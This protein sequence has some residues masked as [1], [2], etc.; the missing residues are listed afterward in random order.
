M[1]SLNVK[2][3]G[4][5]ALLNNLELQED[6]ITY[7]G[8]LH[9]TQNITYS[10]FNT[11]Y[12]FH[13]TVVE[14]DYAV[15]DVSEYLDYQ[16]SFCD[17]STFEIYDYN[18]SL[19][20]VEGVWKIAEVTTNDPFFLSYYNEGFDLQ[21]EIQ[22][23]DSALARNSSITNES[24]PA[25][26]ES[27]AVAA[28]AS[29]SDITYNK[30]N[31]VNYALT[32]STQD[33]D[34]LATPSYRNTSFPWWGADCMNFASQC[35]WAGFGGSNSYSDI[36]SLYGMDNTGSYTWYANNSTGTGSWCSCGS[37]RSYV[38][39]SNASSET[40]LKCS[41]GSVAYNSDQM[42]FS[43]SNLIGSVLH[44][45]GYDNNGNED[46]FAHAVVVNNATGTTREDVYFTGYNIC[47][48]N[49][50]LSL[51][52][53]SSTWNTNNGIF[54]IVPTAF[55]NGSSGLRL[56]TDLH[57]ATLINTPLIL[58]GYSNV[59]CNMFEMDIYNP[60][61]TCVMNYDWYN[62][63]SVSAN[64]NAFNIEGT[65]K[66]VLTGTDSSNNTK[67]FTYTVRIY[68]SNA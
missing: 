5:K 32:Y 17:E 15:T 40:G 36:G 68:D 20:K 21:E 67:T 39:S 25:S 51:S 24:L 47:R 65:W 56:W 66:V 43:S 59:Q 64:F 42:P 49:R 14:G 2:E 41:T 7:F 3:T 28:V 30:Q 22:G 53:P 60:Y 12:Q 16:Y 23:Y 48:K 57:N 50:R 58:K 38:S 31:A 54:V 34:T 37:F 6:R 44:V 18:I 26:P 55:Q 33:D 11:D 62:T 35:I 13:K 46:P 10:Y 45:K 63:S 8:H 27:N 61:G 1:N 9:E 4:T 52:C 19:I 29:S